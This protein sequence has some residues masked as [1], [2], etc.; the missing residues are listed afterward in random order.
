MALSDFDELPHLPSDHPR[1]Q[2][3]FFIIAS[4]ANGETSFLIHCKRWP[5]SGKQVARIAVRAGSKIISRKVEEAIPGGSF[6]VDGLELFPV[7]PYR[8]LKLRGRFEGTPGFGPLGFVAW[9]SDGEI[10]VGIDLTLR[11]ELAPADFAEVFAMRAAK[12]SGDVR[13]LTAEHVQ[14]HYEQGGICEGHVT[15]EGERHTLTGLFVRDHTWGQRD[16]SYMADG[17]FG[18]WTATTLDEGNLFFNALG[19]TTPE[20]VRG[21]GVVVDRAGQAITTDVSVEFLPSPGLHGFTETRVHIGG[22]KPINAIGRAQ[23]H[24]VKYLPGS[25]PRRFDDNALSSVEAGGLT[26]FGV[27]EFA[28]ML[29]AE[30]AAELD[31]Y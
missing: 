13:P 12:F 17:T 1:W 8:E 20:G 24:L 5:A 29:S 9:A 26:G 15:I 14:A 7:K 31:K 28:G 22:D 11:S 6:T 21:M 18:F 4:S 19:R 10:E 27:H 30:E 25:G 16:E 23:V 3:N 2:E